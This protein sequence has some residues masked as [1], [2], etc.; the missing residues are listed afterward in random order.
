MPPRRT[1]MT[2]IA[3]AHGGA[4]TEAHESAGTGVVVPLFP[5]VR[6]SYAPSHGA[7]FGEALCLLREL[8]IRELEVYVIALRRRRPP[9][10]A[11]A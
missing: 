2:D 7:L 5:E 4:S 3:L 10:S 11:G 8:S 6:S 1:C 9:G